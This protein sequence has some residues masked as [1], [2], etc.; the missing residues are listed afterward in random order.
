MQIQ[1]RLFNKRS[2]QKTLW[3]VYKAEQ[4]IDVLIQLKTQE[5]YAIFLEDLLTPSETERILNRFDI[6]IQLYIGTP[7]S[8]LESSIGFSSATIAKISN[9]LRNKQGGFY[10]GIEKL[11]PNGYR[12]FD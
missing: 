1:D 11:Y 8:H 4:L 7:Y 10:L 9:K 6:A 2:R 5:E 12:Y 3:S